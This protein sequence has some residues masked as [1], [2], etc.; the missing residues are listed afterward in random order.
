MVRHRTNDEKIF[1]VE[2]HTSF[3]SPPVHIIKN[4]SAH[5]IG[6]KEISSIYKP[7]RSLSVINNHAML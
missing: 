2:A 7:Q 6:L 1:A 5:R 3:H 4:T